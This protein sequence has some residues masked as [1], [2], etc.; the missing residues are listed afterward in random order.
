MAVSEPR[1][2]M[3]VAGSMLRVHS[4]DLHEHIAQEAGD[5]L[6]SG[7]HTDLAIRCQDGETLPAHRLVLA[8]VSPYL[9]QVLQY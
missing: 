6:A 8:A 1:L 7:S 5:S 4:R 3:A 2:V 9:R